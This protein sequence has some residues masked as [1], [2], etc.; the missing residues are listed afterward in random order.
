MVSWSPCATM[1]S[2][3]LSNPDKLLTIQDI[4][5][6]VVQ[7]SK[8]APRGTRGCGSPFTHQIFGVKEGQYEVTC[9]DHLLNIVQIE[10]T[11]GVKNVEA[12]AAVPGIDIIFVGPFDLAKSMDVEFGGDEHEKAIAKVLEASHKAGKKAAIFCESFRE[13]GDV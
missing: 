9:D 7:M 3:S 6:R 1:R 10:S 5:K 11:D 4:A 2:V 13:S 8:F 12:I